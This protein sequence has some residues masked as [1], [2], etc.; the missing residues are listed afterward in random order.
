MRLFVCAMVAVLG[1][2]MFAVAALVWDRRKD[3]AVR[4]AKRRSASAAA[5]GAGAGA[6]NGTG[7]EGVA[8]ATAERPNKRFV[9]H[10]IALGLLVLGMAMLIGSCAGLLR[11]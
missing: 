5:E 10:G 1:I 3:L 2:G 8:L 9:P 7:G 11:F 4:L 6:A